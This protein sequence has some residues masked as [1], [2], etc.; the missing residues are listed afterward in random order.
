MPGLWFIGA[1]ENAEECTRLSIYLKRDVLV[2]HLITYSWPMPAL[3]PSW[4]TLY[5]FILRYLP[6]LLY[7]SLTTH[8]R[9][10]RFMVEKDMTVR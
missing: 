3:L 5:L 6:S 4:S 2:V 7:A 1:R 10:R 9:T 8:T